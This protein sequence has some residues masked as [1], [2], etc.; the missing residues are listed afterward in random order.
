MVLFRYR[1]WLRAGREGE[2]P[3]LTDEARGERKIE[4]YFLVARPDGV[5]E[6]HDPEGIE[7]L[8]DETYAVGSGE[9]AARAA[10]HLGASA[11]E[12]VQVAAEL[13]VY[14]GG[15]IHSER[16]GKPTT[17]TEITEHP[18]ENIDAPTREWRDRYN[19]RSRSR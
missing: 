16:V 5:L 6:F 4:S 14:T 11:T 2:R 12:A 10:L 9:M 13:D 1:E 3:S 8:E 15:A 19:L 18:I 7:E 17:L